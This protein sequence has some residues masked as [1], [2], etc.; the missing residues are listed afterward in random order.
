VD[1]IRYLDEAP[2]PGSPDGGGPTLELAYLTEDNSNP[3][4]WLS[5]KETGGTPGSLNSVTVP[6]ATDGAPELPTAVAIEAAYP[7][8]FQ[9]ATTIPFA[10]PESG[11]VTIRVYNTLG[12]VVATLVDAQKPAGRH[13][14]QWTA[15]GRASGVYFY[16]LQLN[17]TRK[18]TG[19]AVLVR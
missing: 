7:N 12:Q 13:E 10:L 3:R 1:E 18:A 17:G 14:V 4:F 2:W 11:H 9:D 15:S 5:S 19:K 16:E 6:V 8:P